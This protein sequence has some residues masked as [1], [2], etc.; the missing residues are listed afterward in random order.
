[1]QCAHAILPSVPCPALPYF[2][3]LSHKR[4]DFRKKV[5]EPKM[6]FLIFSTTFFRNISHSTKNWARYDQKCILVFMQST[7]YCCQIVM[8][9]EFL[10]AGFRNICKYQI[11]WKSVQ[12]EPSYSMRTDGRTGMTKLI[13]AFRYSVNAPNKTRTSMPSAGCEPAIPAI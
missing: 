2:P 3:T 1:M 7:G 5:T 13:V 10:S 4:H 12:W 8:K 9:L 11:S 6:C